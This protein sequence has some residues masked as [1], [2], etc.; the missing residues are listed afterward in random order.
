LEKISYLQIAFMNQDSDI[1]AS[2][3]KPFRGNQEGCPNYGKR[4]NC[5]PYA[6]RIE[7]TQERIRSRK[8][9]FLLVGRTE[10]DSK[11]LSEEAIGEYK[12]LVQCNYRITKALRGKWPS[13]LIFYGPSCTYCV[14]ENVGECTCP[15]EPCRFPDVW[16]YPPE[17]VGVDVFQTMLNAGIKM[18]RNPVDVVFN[19]GL[20]CLSGNINLSDFRKYFFLITG[21]ER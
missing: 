10:I 5:P 14:D 16:T 13:I 19:V 11:N 7:I 17:A 12:K 3:T 21:R 1:I 20:I 8:H 18:Q 6:P 9:H 4:W 15:S 2:C